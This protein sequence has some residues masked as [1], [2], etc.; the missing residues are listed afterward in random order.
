ML[1]P[2]SVYKDL[3]EHLFSVLLGRHLGVEPLVTLCLTFGGTAPFYIPASSVGEVHIL[4]IFAN[5]FPPHFF[6]S[7][8]VFASSLQASWPN[9]Q[10]ACTEP[11]MSHNR[12]GVDQ[13]QDISGKL[14]NRTMIE[15]E[16]LHCPH[17]PQK[18]PQWHKEKRI[19]A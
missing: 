9:L 4:H 7:K 17:S 14:W 13:T 19:S 6:D 2:T 1:P 11:P 8:E 18:N 3:C 16:S 12:L 15:I 10:V 5:T